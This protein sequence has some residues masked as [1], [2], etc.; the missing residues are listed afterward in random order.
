MTVDDLVKMNG[1]IHSVDEITEG[2]LVRIGDRLFHQNG[3]EMTHDPGPHLR[4]EKVLESEVI[5]RC[6]SQE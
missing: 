3:I 5:K 1:R 2:G 4:F 6:G